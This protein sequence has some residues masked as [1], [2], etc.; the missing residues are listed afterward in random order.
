MEELQSLLRVGSLEHAVRW[1]QRRYIDPMN[2]GTETAADFRRNVSPYI[3][4]ADR[5]LTPYAMGRLRSLAILGVQAGGIADA[6]GSPAVTG[7]SIPFGTG[8]GSRAL[9][10]GEHV[11]EIFQTTVTSRGTDRH[12]VLLYS[13]R[14]LSRRVILERLRDANFDDADGSREQSRRQQLRDRSG[15][16][17]YTIGA[18]FSG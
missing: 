13:K 1:Y 9:D 6:V 7:P 16:M 8:L 14:P 11:Y 17:S 10:E 4:G 3:P 5:L 2:A 15:R 12:R 18:V